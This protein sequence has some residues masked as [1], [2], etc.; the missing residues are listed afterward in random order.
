MREN[1]EPGRYVESQ[2]RVHATIVH[3]MLKYSDTARYTAPRNHRTYTPA[4]NAELV[5]MPRGSWVTGA[6]I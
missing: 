4:F 1:S 2:H 5:A 6:A 3:T